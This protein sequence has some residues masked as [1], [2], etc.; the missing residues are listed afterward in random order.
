MV[1]GST[2]APSVARLDTHE[3]EILDFLGLAVFEDVEVLWLETLDNLAVLLRIGIDRDEDRAAAERRW[4]R[5]LR[6]EQGRRQQ[7]QG[8][9][10]VGPFAA[11]M[12]PALW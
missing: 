12:T 6:D 8:Q 9:S 1:F 7:A 3:I 10:E 5:L 4:R 11:H 2:R